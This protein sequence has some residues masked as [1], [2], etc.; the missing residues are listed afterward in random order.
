[1][2]CLTPTVFNWCEGLLANMKNQLTKCKTGCLKQFGYGSILV[3]FFLEHVP[4]FHYQWIEVD[5]PTPT[6][7]R[8]LRWVEIMPRVGRGQRMHFPLSLFDWLWH[9]LIIMDDYA[10]VG[11]NFRGYLDL[12]LPPGTQWTDAG[13]N[14][15]F[16]IFKVL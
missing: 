10:Y 6:N 16:G 14:L 13:K 15:F 9:Q 8:L 2:D 12:P 1:M 4:L 11:T 7:T 3:T 5:D